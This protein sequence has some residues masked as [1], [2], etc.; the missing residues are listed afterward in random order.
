VGHDCIIQSIKGAPPVYFT[1]DEYIAT[2]PSFNW[3]DRPYATDG[4]RV[5]DGD[6][7]TFRLNPPVTISAIKDS[8]DWLP[9]TDSGAPNMTWTFRT[10]RT[11]KINLGCNIEG[12]THTWCVFIDSDLPHYFRSGM[13]TNVPEADASTR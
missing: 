2:P 1:L 13:R 7:V 12:A 4:H 8:G 11:G 9:T 5:Q 3:K 6:R 10:S